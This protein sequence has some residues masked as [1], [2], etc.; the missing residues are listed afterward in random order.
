MQPWESYIVGVESGSIVA[1]RLIK[2]S[3]ER[4]RAMEANPLIYFDEQRVVRCVKFFG[5]LRHFKGKAAGKQFILEPWQQYI[6]ATVIGWRYVDGGR[7]VIRNLYIQMARKN[8]KTA[9]VAGLLLY[10]SLADGEPGAE[11]DLAANSREQAKIC[12]EFVNEFARQLDG[13]ATRLLRYRDRISDKKTKSKIQVFAADDS[14]LD[15][16]D[17]S[18]YVLDEYHAAKNSRLRDVLDSSQGSRLQPLGIIITTAGF[19]KLSA[20]YDYRK[21]CVEVLAGIRQDEHL[22]AFIFELDDNDD[23]HDTQ[24]WAKANP[25]MG[26]TVDSDYIAAKVQ[27]C[28]N[29]PSAEVGVRTKVLNQ[30]CDA[31][32]VWIPD[33]YIVSST[34][35]IDEGKMSELLCF[36]GIDLSTT[37]DLSAFTAMW[38]DEENYIY[39][40]KTRYYLPRESL[41]ENRFRVL[42]GEW[43]RNGWLTITPGNVIDYDYILNDVVDISRAHR[44]SSVAYDSYNATQFV[45]NATNKGLP[46]KPF[47]QALGNFNRPT[48]EF[49]RLLLSGRCVIDDNPIT[50]HCFRNVAL[51]RDHNGNIKPSKQF[52]EK[53]IDGTITCLEALGA[54][55]EEP[56]GSPTL[57]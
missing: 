57:F 18:V 27:E 46:M 3:V 17:A 36:G 24:V 39:Y 49:E 23:W 45:I 42:Y 34:K 30:W 12:F 38:V 19:D 15:G 26:V 54:Y 6:I 4:W 13:R 44:L 33:H 14:K 52:A 16:F 28:S 31:E 20:C 21:M 2:Q 22:A 10:L 32:E 9:F 48:K 29:Q 5:L 53:K 41:T 43:A 1:G 8:G 50:R 40:F 55:L 56:H 51:A 35:K 11:G 25:N 47:S 7:R 37:T